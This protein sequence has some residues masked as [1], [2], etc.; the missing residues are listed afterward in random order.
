MFAEPVKI[1]KTFGVHENMVVADLGAGSGFYT[2][3]LAQ[4]AVGGKVYA[5]EIQKDF[6]LTIRNKVKEYKLDNVECLWGNIEIKGGTRLGDNVAD[7]V[8]VSNVFFQVEHKEKFLDEVYRIIKPSG[9]VLLIDWHD[10]DSPLAPKGNAL[11][12]EEKARSFFEQKGFIFEKNVDAGDHHYG[13]I[14]KVKK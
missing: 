1:L 11:V 2:L 7:R 14:F 13:M 8:V 6:L 12:P 9:K 5:I 3:P 4:M 10:A